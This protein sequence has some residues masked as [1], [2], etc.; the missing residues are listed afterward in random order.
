M[1]GD[2]V[3]V[4]SAEIEKVDWDFQGLVLDQVAESVSDTKESSRKV[5]GISHVVLV[6]YIFT[7]LRWVIFPRAR[8]RTDTSLLN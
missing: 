1:R 7:V 2:E 6:F 3:G 4:V 8:D 5:V